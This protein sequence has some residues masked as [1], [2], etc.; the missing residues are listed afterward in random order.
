M[1]WTVEFEP[2]AAK[3][4]R[5]LD[6]QRQRR[7]LD[8]IDK[9]AVFAQPSLQL[10]RLSGVLNHLYKLRVGNYRVLCE[11]RTEKLLIIV[12]KIGHRRDIYR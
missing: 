5:K 1:A 12:V 9:L 7:L 11:L 6:P 3:F 10:D 8:A 4:I 2:A